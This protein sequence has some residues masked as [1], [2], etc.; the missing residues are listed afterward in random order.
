MTESASQSS[1]N[2]L[3]EFHSEATDI[4]FLVFSVIGLGI[5]CLAELTHLSV[6]VDVLGC[7]VLV[8]SLIALMTG[9]RR[10]QITK[11]LAVIGWIGVGLLALR[12][13]PGSAHPALL[14]I[15]PAVASLVIG[16]R[17]G[18]VT[19]GLAMI[20]TVST[21]AS[22]TW[23]AAAVAIGGT[24]ILIWLC[25]K[26]NQET[27]SSLWSSYSQMNQLLEEARNQR[28]EL[29]QVQE[30]LIQAN[31][32]L[33]RLSDRLSVMYRV[34]EDAR[35]AQEEFVANVSHE[36]RTP[37]NMIIG[38]SQMITQMPNIYGS[39][40]PP[41]LL[42][43]LAVV[44]RN[45]E[46]LAA[47]V[48]DVL[49][50]SQVASGQ[51][52]LS[53][54]WTTLNDLVDSAVV[55]VKPLFDAKGLTLETHVPSTLPPV[56]C[57]RTRVR[58]VL[59]NLLSNAG[60]FTE[61]GGASVAIQRDGNALA[62]AVSDTGPGIPA[63]KLSR[64][65]E[66]FQQ[67]DSTI[68]RKFGGSGLGLS[69]SKKF[70][71][72]H[73]GRM[74]LTSEP[75]KG[76]TFYFTLPVQEPAGAGQPGAAQ[77]AFARDDYNPR[78]RQSKAPHPKPLPR[79]IIVEPSHVLQ[80]L[81]SRYL[82]GV[83]VCAAFCIEEAVAELR[84][85][86]A[87]A[88][89]I[90][91]PRDDKVPVG[92]TSLPFPTSIITCWVPG[93][94]EAADSLGVVRY[95]LKPVK[96]E[97]LLDAVG[98]VGSVT[99]IL[100]VD[101]EPEVLQLFGRILTAA[102]RCYRVLRASDG[103]RALDILRKRHPDLMLLDMVLPGMDGYAVLQEKA[104]DPLIRDIPVIAITGQ[105]PLGHQHVGNTITIRRSGGMTTKDLL[106]L[107]RTLSGVSRPEPQDDLGFAENPA[108]E[109]AS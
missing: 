83:E 27:V 54:E 12:W 88:L 10:Y 9:E 108:A 109:P 15:P 103:K 38:Y 79:F 40:L 71:E 62:I 102:G 33:A 107:I 19:A 85:S 80:R 20:A 50:L 75:H 5:T 53:N 7:I 3:E 59:L 94:K 65:F 11:W 51:M 93:E 18:F 104:R 91:S 101:D 67:A 49:D 31:T 16:P 36:L 78:L 37:L 81:I 69:I 42:A 89:I 95:L 98:E 77:W 76:T 97:L 46:H 44:H 30:D 100:I 43:D 74:W 25:L 47:L 106:A 73:R 58:Q 56:Y 8:L 22:Q 1:A 61:R 66:P 68:R 32:Q 39:E 17:G 84:R 34:A 48:D 29:K 99:T 6:D 41:P 70:V 45:S 28:V 52:A 82:A 87:H 92:M 23:A 24:Q 96:R 55:A 90:N 26:L 35:R 21:A 2:M 86:P 57:D 105:D 4:L 14:A 63:D 60:R 64:I 13:F 72:L